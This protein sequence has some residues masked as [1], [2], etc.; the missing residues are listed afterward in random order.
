MKHS[1]KNFLHHVVLAMLASTSLIACA[2]NQPAEPPA[3]H[4]AAKVKTQQIQIEKRDGQSQVVLVADGKTEVLQLS[5]ADLKNEAKLAEVL[6]K[7]PAEQRDQVK[8]MLL[9]EPKMHGALQ[10]EPQIFLTM[11]KAAGE[12]GNTTERHIVVKKL[13]GD[14]TEPQVLNVDVAGDGPKRQVVIQTMGDAALDGKAGFEFFKA[15]LGNAKLDKNQLQEL[16]KLLD[17]KH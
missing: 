5:A 7:L 6:A 4:A 2:S 15:W 1:K 3:N 8:T 11:D 12:N 14:G 9:N 13:V 16:Q 17:S 10:G